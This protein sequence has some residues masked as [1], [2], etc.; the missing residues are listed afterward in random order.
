MKTT[1][2]DIIEDLESLGI[3]VVWTPE[4]DVRLHPQDDEAKGIMHAMWDE[5]KGHVDKLRV[6]LMALYAIKAVN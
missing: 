5:L 4:H 6:R 3:R 2:K 1:A